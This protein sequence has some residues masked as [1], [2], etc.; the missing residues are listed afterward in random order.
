MPRTFTSTAP[1]ST[2]AD[3]KRRTDPASRAAAREAAPAADATSRR[4][5]TSTYATTPVATQSENH[6]EN[7]AT[8]PR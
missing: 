8:K 4:N 5:G 3:T 7:D 1:Q 2:A 6:C